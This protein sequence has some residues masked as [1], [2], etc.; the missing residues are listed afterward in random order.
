MIAAAVAPAMKS[1]STQ[2]RK[3]A[4][5]TA[6]PEAVPRGGGL[7]TPPIRHSLVH[8]EFSQDLKGSRSVLQSGVVHFL[9][10]AVDDVQIVPIHQAIV[11]SEGSL[12]ESRLFLCCKCTFV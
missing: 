5:G 2:L 12:G 11:A 7:G 9:E 1:V 3:S 8:K 6:R 4:A 10:V